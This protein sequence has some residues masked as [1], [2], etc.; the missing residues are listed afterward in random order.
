M[1][2]AAV[3]IV[4][5]PFE[6]QPRVWSLPGYKVIVDFGEQEHKTQLWAAKEIAAIVT[7]TVLDVWADAE[8]V[9]GMP[10]I[11][12]S[13]G[14]FLNNKNV[15]SVI[16][17]ELQRTGLSAKMVQPG[18]NPVWSR[19]IRTRDLAGGVISPDN[20]SC[21]NDRGRRPAG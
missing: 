11:F 20:H 18:L 1:A 10:R 14:E 5:A 12:E 8:I 9:G 3:A 19:R 21:T 13:Y 4:F 17:T 2:L 16:M 6:V 7:K 15:E